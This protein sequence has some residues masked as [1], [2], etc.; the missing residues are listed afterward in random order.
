MKVLKKER[1]VIELALDHLDKTGEGLQIMIGAMR[2][3][4]FAEECHLAHVGSVR[5]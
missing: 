2:A 3:P 5:Q 4:K 1:K